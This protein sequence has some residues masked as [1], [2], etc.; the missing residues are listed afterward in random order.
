MELIHS[1]HG[2]LIEQH[3]ILEQGHARTLELLKR[4]KSGEVKIANVELTPAGWKIS[5]P[6]RLP[7]SWPCKDQA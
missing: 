1:L 5:E 3:A 6:K 4:L 7:I 2:V